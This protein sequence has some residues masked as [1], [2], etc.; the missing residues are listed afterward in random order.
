MILLSNTIHIPHTLIH[1]NISQ[2]WTY[3]LYENRSVFGR[4]PRLV[5][6]IFLHLPEHVAQN[7]ELKSKRQQERQGRIEKNREVDKE[8]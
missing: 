1:G 8:R 3:R 4:L 2:D 5:N 6:D 7:S